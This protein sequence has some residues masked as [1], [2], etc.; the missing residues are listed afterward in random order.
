MSRIRTSNDERKIYELISWMF[1][2]VHFRHF[3]E[4]KMRY[5]LI[6]QR[7]LLSQWLWI[8]VYWD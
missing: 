2:N 4:L 3:D 1:H 7:I 5:L 6:L 8:Y